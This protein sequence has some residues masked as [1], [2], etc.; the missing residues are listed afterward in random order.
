MT[1]FMRS[2]NILNWPLWLKLSLGFLAAILAPVVILLI[3]AAGILATI[4]RDSLREQVRQEGLHQEQALSASLQQAF[5]TLESITHLSGFDA[6]LPLLLSEEGRNVDRARTIADQ[7]RN[8]VFETKF[9]QSMRLVAVNGD[10][11]ARATANDIQTY[12]GSDSE[13]PAFISALNASIQKQGA[14][15]SVSQNGTA[16]IEFSRVIENEKREAIG[17][18][19]AR[20]NESLALKPLAPVVDNAYTYLITGGQPPTV[21]DLSENPT[22]VEASLENPVVAQRALNGQQAT[23][24]YAVG[25]QKNIEVAGF[26]S[27]IFNPASPGQVL[28]ALV[29]E[30]RTDTATNLAAQYLDGSRG[31][32]IGIGLLV[33]LALL[34]LLFNQIITPPLMNLRKAMQA[35]AKGD[36]NHP[37]NTRRGD[38]VGALSAAFVDMRTHVRDLLDDLEARM[39]A[40]ARDI[41]A[42]QDVSRFAA[43]QRNLQT[44]LDQVVELIVEK[45]P[46]I[47]QAQVFLTD[48]E[49]EN[50]VLRASTGE[51]GRVMLARGH[52]LSVGGQSLVGQAV[53]QGQLMVVRDTATSLIHR[54]NEFLPDTRAELVI[55]LR[56]GDQIMG[57][58]DVQSQARNTF[59]EQEVAI[60]QTMADQVA[61]AIENARLYQE[62][63]RRLEQI[64]QVN[65]NATLK[66]WQEYI[67]SQHERSLSSQAGTTTG[68]DLSALRR[69]AIEQ[70]RII[71]GELT[72]NQT[73]PIAVPIQLRGQTLGAVE[74]EIPES[75]FSNNKLQMAQELA[76]RLAVSL[77]NARLF[78]E[79]QRATERERI[80][81][82]I[83]AKLTPQTEIDDILQTAV[84][85]VGQALRAPQVSIRLHRPPVEQSSNGHGA[86]PI[87]DN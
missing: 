12:A 84:R 32:V 81:N 1:S 46:N 30:V 74:W 72:A 71:V 24:F 26:Y 38:E 66:T 14:V 31:F 76:N 73:V 80:V 37:V 8:Q 34:A 11:I 17:Y 44:L 85:E 5:I 58:L 50:A 7:L 77:D 57:A 42:T 69:R 75:D 70:G 53:L 10:I 29:T 86:H 43:T 13:T 25:R 3:A 82:A 4:G 52:R 65:R 6:G 55:P 19:I 9:F 49:G 68:N 36:F 23:A 15:I 87:S 48:T 51:A 56:S 33:T 79:S 60:L 28:F 18:F 21:I 20:L 63:M 59:D 61:V 16:V 67:Y 40:R 47:Y 27:P 83:S 54:P 22:L 62:S 39:A 45:F 35:V 41:S 78:Q 64:E 2:L